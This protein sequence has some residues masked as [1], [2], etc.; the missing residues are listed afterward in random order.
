M[1]MDSTFSPSLASRPAACAIHTGKMVTTGAEM[2]IL[3]GARSSAR[4]G[5]AASSAINVSQQSLRPY[6]FGMA[7]SLTVIAAS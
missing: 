2:P 7:F 3:N 1:L 6:P 5:S 4:A